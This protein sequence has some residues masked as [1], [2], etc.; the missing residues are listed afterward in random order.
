MRSI[1]L[2]AF[3]CLCFYAKGQAFISY[4][5]SINHFSINVPADWYYKE[6]YLS[7]KLVAFKSPNSKSGSPGDNFNI[8]IIETPGA[9][10]EKA[11]T[12]FMYYLPEDGDSLRVIATGDTVFHGTAFKWLIETHLMKKRKWIKNYDFV[13]FKKGKTFI[14]TMVSNVN[15]FDIVK[16]LFDKIASSF[17]F[18]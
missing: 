18:K 8:N 15:Y 4:K 5:D 12:D 9:S 14:L 11:F 10:L 16:P 17:T 1:L 6:N 2:L 7:L 13:T 3:I